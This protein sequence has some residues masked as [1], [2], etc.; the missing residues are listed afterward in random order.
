[1]AALE[2]PVFFLIGL[3]VLQE[4]GGAPDGRMSQKSKQSNIEYATNATAE[5][6]KLFWVPAEEQRIRGHKVPR[7]L[8]P[9]CS[10]DCCESVSLGKAQGAFVRIHVSVPE[11]FFSR[12]L[13]LRTATAENR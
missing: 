7:I 8:E 9:D 10:P 5:K 12:L 2:F 11:I 13:R 4:R 1:M 6:V 3:F